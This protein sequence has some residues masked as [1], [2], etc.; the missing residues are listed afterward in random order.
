MWT[1]G[2]YEIKETEIWGSSKR[3]EKRIFWSETGF[4]GRMTL[5]VDNF[6]VLE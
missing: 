1:R 4:R 5:G 6:S 3:P 2:S